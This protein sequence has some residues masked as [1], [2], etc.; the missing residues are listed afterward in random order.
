MSRQFKDTH[1]YFP[2]AIFDRMKQLAELNRRSMSAEVIIAVEEHLALNKPT[3]LLADKSR[4]KKTGAEGEMIPRDMEL[5]KLGWVHKRLPHCAIVNS[6][7]ID[8]SVNYRIKGER[9]SRYSKRENFL[10]N[11]YNVNT[12]QE[13]PQ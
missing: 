11:W 10:K 9:K 13:S 7:L 2:P 1:I 8:G 5:P 4:R 12:E 3:L 6:V